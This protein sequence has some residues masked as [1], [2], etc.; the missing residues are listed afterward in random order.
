MSNHV[1][2]KSKVYLDNGNQI[3]LPV[4]LVNSQ[5][6]LKSYLEYLIQHKLNS[7]SWIDASTHAICLFLDYVEAKQHLY[8]KPFHLFQSFSEALFIGT[9]DE[10]GN[11]ESDLRWTCRDI[12]AANNIISYVTQYTDWLSIK[13]NNSDLQLNPF[14]EATSYEQKLN[15][16]AYI[17]KKEGAFLAHT[18][19]NESAQKS[20]S[21][22]RHVRGRI[23]PQVDDGDKP[24]FPE[25]KINELLDSFINYKHRY[26]Y[27]IIKKFNYK[28]IL[29]TILLNFG[30]L[31]RSEP[32]HLWIEDVMPH[33]EN[34]E[35]AL[36]RVYHPSL[37]KPPES[38][39][40]NQNFNRGEILRHKYKLK[41]RNEYEKSKKIH[42]GWKNLRLENNGKYVAVNWFEPNAGVVFMFYWTLYLK[43]QR[44]IP[45]KSHDHPFAFTNKFGAP[46]S[47]SAYEKQHKKAVESIG[48]DVEKCL[49]TTPQGHRHAY[50]RRLTD[51]KI[52]GLMI[53]K[54]MNHKSEESKK[55][56]QQY[57]VNE[58]RDAMKSINVK[59]RLTGHTDGE[60]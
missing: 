24:A 10:D 43:Y 11:D 22:S 7:Q 44:I 51:A 34:S 14:K 26:H 30:G 35:E 32:F 8:N 60:D 20:N 59:K 2:I 56:Y 50:G 15:W 28:D 3:R 42:A 37:S 31:R 5:S 4:I 19:S 48:L 41:P 53:T 33:P 47:I 23:A 54:A 13:F 39:I 25:D 45:K 18:W 40:Y 29:I 9:T 21:L 57:S 36:V 17:H 46:Y 55:A 1:V 49:G 38:I 6:V 58:L 16:A 12:K 52:Q 27:S